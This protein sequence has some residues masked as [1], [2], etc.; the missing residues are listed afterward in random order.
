MFYPST[1]SNM[2]LNTK[3]SDCLICKTLF[4]IINMY[5][6]ILIVKYNRIICDK[7]LTN[8]MEL[9]YYGPVNPLDSGPAGQFN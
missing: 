3:V 4:C 9:R 1:V 7:C 2:F 8:G 5:H 6:E